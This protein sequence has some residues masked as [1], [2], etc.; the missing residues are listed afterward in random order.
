MRIQEHGWIMTEKCQE[1]LEYGGLNKPEVTMTI[2]ANTPSI[3]TVVRHLWSDRERGE[4]LGCA[5]MRKMC[6]IPKKY[7]TAAFLCCR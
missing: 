7:H 4:A 5:A 1:L 3:R 2:T 6:A